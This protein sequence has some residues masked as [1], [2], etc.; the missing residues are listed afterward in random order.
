MN[1]QSQFAG[2]EEIFVNN[3]YDKV[4]ILR[5]QKELQSLTIDKNYFVY[6]YENQTMKSVEII[7]QR[8]GKRKEGE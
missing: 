5:K 7:L 2:W 6:V 3:E 1:W 4:L 8:E